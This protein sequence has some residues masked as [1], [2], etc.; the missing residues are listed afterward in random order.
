MHPSYWGPDA[1]VFRPE[2][3]DSL[4]DVSNTTFMT[5]QNGMLLRVGL[6]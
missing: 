4:K 5:F 1:H 3:W 2:R 6:M